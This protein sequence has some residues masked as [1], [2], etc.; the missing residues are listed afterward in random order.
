MAPVCGWEQA[1]DG[2]RGLRGVGVVQNKQPILCALK[3]SAQC[4]NFFHRSETGIDRQREFWQFGEGVAKD[5][6]TVGRSPQDMAVALPLLVRVLNG[7]LGFADPAQ[8]V[9]DEDVAWLQTMECS[10]DFWKRGKVWIQS[11]GP[12]ER[13]HRMRG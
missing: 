5:L 9:E 4:A 6:L 3:P 10:L 12:W 2:A 8:S 7:M 13:K 1:L 11:V